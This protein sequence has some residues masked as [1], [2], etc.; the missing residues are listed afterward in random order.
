VGRGVWLV[1]ARLETG[2]TH[3]VRIHLA[4]AGHPVLGDPLYARH[5]LRRFPRLALHAFKLAFRHPSHG[6]PMRFEVPLAD[7]LE[8]GMRVFRGEEAG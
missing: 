6:Q 8:R 4:E 3:Q 5:A 1:E 2:R 7:D